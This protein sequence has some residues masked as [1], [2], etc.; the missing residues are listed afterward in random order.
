MTGALFLL[1]TDAATERVGNMALRRRAEQRIAKYGLEGSTK[2]QRLLQD[3]VSNI[4]LDGLSCVAGTPSS[5][6]V[7]FKVTTIQYY[8]ALESSE[9]ISNHEVEDLAISLFEM[10]SSRTLWCT[11]E[12]S[13]PINVITPPVRK[14]AVLQQ[15]PERMSIDVEF[16]QVLRLYF[17][18]SF[19]FSIAQLLNS[20]RI[21]DRYRLK[22][23]EDWPLFLSR[24]HH[25]MRL[26]MTVRTR[27]RAFVKTFDLACP[28][29]TFCLF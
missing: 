11:S 13:P 2:L 20:Q 12:T 3:R 16:S 15:Y 6:D 29:T 17:S 5:I 9:I 10:V 18:H 24:R 1:V 7:A 8:Y 21:I 14:L 28:N 27:K 4:D 19:I 26:S 22:R 23:P 25:S